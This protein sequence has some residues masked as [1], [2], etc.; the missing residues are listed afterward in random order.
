MAYHFSLDAV[1]KVLDLQNKKKET[2]KTLIT[3]F[4]CPCKPTKT[5]GMRTRNMPWDA[6]E[7]W[8]LYKEYNKYDV[9][10]EREIFRLLEKYEIPEFEREMYILD[11]AIND[12][13][14]LV[15]VELAESAIAVDNEYSSKLM[16][17]SI[18]ISGLKIQILQ[19]NLKNM[20][21]EKLSLLIRI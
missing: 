21:Q 5:N 7:K 17:E 2:G 13:G 4:A 8:E 3:Y 16:Q 20:L 9:L 19:C 10:A 15:D 14:I 12:R 1:S 18:E 6:P 11:Q